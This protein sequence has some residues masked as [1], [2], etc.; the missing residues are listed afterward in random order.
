MTLGHT[1]LTVGIH[2]ALT[3]RIQYVTMTTDTVLGV[4]W[5]GTQETSVINVCF[6]KNMFVLYDL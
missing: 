1:D 3:V 6:K 2:A 4:V 5:M